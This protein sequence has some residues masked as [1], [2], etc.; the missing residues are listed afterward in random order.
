MA[1]V[2][3]ASL[4]AVT[5]SC[6]ALGMSLR[7][8]RRMFVAA[9]MPLAEPLSLNAV[10]EQSVCLAAACLSRPCQDLVDMQLACG[11]GHAKH[12]P[13]VVAWGCRAHAGYN[14]HKAAA[15]RMSAVPPP[16]VPYTRQLSMA[17]C[18]QEAE[19]YACTV[20]RCCAGSMWCICV[21]YMPYTQ[22][23]LSPCD[24]CAATSATTCSHGRAD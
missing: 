13:F 19:L 10:A 3:T 4:P 18:I 21:V 20:Q 23:S 7:P 6:R 15:S 16:Y 12:V 2:L 8:L 5:L 14:L 17:V 24:A 9:P 1:R 11:P 22:L